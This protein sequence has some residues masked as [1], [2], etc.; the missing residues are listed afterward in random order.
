MEFS[1]INLFNGII[2]ICMLLPNIIWAI[3]NRD[4]VQRCSSHLMNVIEQVGRYGSMILMVVPLFVWKF[5]FQSVVAMVICFG[6]SSILVMTYWIIWIFYF[7]QKTTWNQIALALIPCMI[8]L[9]C[10][11]TLGHWA[12]VITAIA[13]VVGHLY[14]T[15][16]NI[17]AD[18]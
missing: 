12:L 13:F 15:I 16:K 7:K 5:S 8:F 6:G 14:I 18:K 11:I 4:G 1:F 17:I 9:L 3:Q 2:L 10:G